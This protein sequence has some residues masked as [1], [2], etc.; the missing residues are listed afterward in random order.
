MA[1]P[2]REELIWDSGRDGM[3]M[4]S[5][6]GFWGNKIN[7]KQERTRDHIYLI[8]GTEIPF[9]RDFLKFI[10]KV[11]KSSPDSQ[12]PQNKYKHIPAGCCRERMEFLNI[13][14]NT[15]RQ[16]LPPLPAAGAGKNPTWEFLGCSL[17]IPHWDRENSTGGMSPVQDL[18]SD[19]S[20]PRQDFMGRSWARTR[21]RP[22][23]KG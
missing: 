14:N 5:A 23:P 10:L 21:T 1:F 16:P 3:R 12:K 20:L 22:G 15:R 17:W 6:R 18:G 4:D 8:R 9:Q 7:E 13:L 2:A 11:S 19:P